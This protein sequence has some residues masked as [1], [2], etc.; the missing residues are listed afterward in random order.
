LFVTIKGNN[1][2][3]SASIKFVES[4]NKCIKVSGSFKDRWY[5]KSSLY[6]NEVTFPP[7]P[8][9]LF[10]IL[11]VPIPY[12]STGTKSDLNSK[13]SPTLILITFSVVIQDSLDLAVL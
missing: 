11:N 10:V 1:I 12:P 7:I 4:L 6:N 2:K 8:Y 3:L 13:L 5:L 9:S